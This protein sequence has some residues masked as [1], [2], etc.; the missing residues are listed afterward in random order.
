MSQA[1][2]SRPHE[3]SHNRAFAIGVA[4]T[5]SF[6]VGE[7]V[8]GIL[9]SSLALVADA[10][11]NLS[12]VLALLLAW[13]AATLSRRLPTARRTYGLKRSSVLA[14]LANAVALFVVVGGVTWE[15]IRRLQEPE[16]VAGELV[17]AVAAFGV[18]INSVSAAMFLAGSKED[19]N[20]RGA[21]LH[22][23][24]DAAVSVGVIAAGIAILATGWLW[25]DPAVSIG[26]SLVILLGTWGLL[27]DSFNLALDA[28]PDQIDP[29]AVTAYLA[30]VPD[31]RDVHDLHIWGMSTTE[32]ALTVHL[33]MGSEAADDAILDDALLQEIREQLEARFGIDHATIQLE[34][35]DPSHP[36]ELAPASVI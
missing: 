11:H 18:L 15:A 20:L 32:T 33:V 22:L 25:L 3:A 36:C 27:R 10:G 5:V 1:H 24:S 17:I 21:F 14:A 28:V 31:V 8:F 23:A 26:I 9:A 16:P 30:S 35:G 4:L 34:Q 29:A 7:A 2:A 19:L 13:G 12:D 6:V